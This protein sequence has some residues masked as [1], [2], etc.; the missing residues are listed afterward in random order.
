MRARRCYHGAIMARFFEYPD[1][2]LP[3]EEG[4]AAGVSLRLLISMRWAAVI[5]QAAALLVIQ[6]GLGFDLPIV[7]ALAVVAA[8]ALINVGHAL[9]RRPQRRLSERDAAFTLGYDVLQLG[10]L[11]YL[12]GG[13]QNPFAILM[14]APVTVA[15]TIL[16]GRS[17]ICLSALAVS[18]I[19][20]L[21]VSHWPLPWQ[22]AP[23][24]LPPIFVFGIWTALVLSTIFIAAYAWSV[25]GEARRVRDAYAAT[26]LALAREQRISAVG[27]LAAAAAHELGSP[28]GTIAVIAKELVRELPADSPYA[29]DAALLLSQSER[30]RT[31]LA[32][33]AQRP[34]AEGSSPFTRLPISALV[35]AAGTPYRAGGVRV[36]YAT[37]DSTGE[38]PLVAR[39]PEI[40]HGLGNLIQNAIQFAHREVTATIAWDRETV[41]VEIVDD[42]PGF[43]PH[44]LPRLGQPYLSSRNPPFGAKSSGGRGGEAQHIGAHHMG[45]GIFIAQTLLERTGARLDFAN[46]PEGGAHIV[47]RWARAALE[48]REDRHS[49]QEV[50]A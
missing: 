12:T 49:K 26:Q 40:M 3:E 9:L 18:A 2:V 4:G 29:E 28:L 5:G 22:G 13:L 20:V 16:S 33:L 50:L 37:T 48:A 11:L 6:Y 15:A 45:L 10:L 32:E 21:A 43:A 31:I 47:L 17:V 14:I 7:P 25:A 35:E 30:C 27:A 23:P 36:I 1:T 8:S 19:T 41:T 39:S 34:E 46:L 38:E 44:L 24:A 42:G